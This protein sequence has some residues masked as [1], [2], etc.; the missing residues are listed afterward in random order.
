MKKILIAEDSNVVKNI[1]KK[2]LEARQYVVKSARNGQAVYDKI[3][4]E[5]FDLILMD[6]NMPIMDGVACTKK[7]RNEAPQE[8]RKIPIFSITGSDNNY[9]E[10]TFA[11]N[12]INEYIQ[13]PIDYDVLMQKIAEYLD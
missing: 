4:K 12:G 6:I 7:I 10:E 9:N 1:T 2:V 8:K 3:L 13:K 11:S 5:D